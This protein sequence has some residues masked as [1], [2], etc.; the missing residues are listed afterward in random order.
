MKEIFFRKE[1]SQ[2]RILE[3][4]IAACCW[5]EISKGRGI[6]Y[7]SLFEDRIKGKENT[8]EH[9]LAYNELEDLVEIHRIWETRHHEFPGL[10]EKFKAIFT[11][12]PI[13]RENERPESSGNRPRNDSFV[14]FL[15]GSLIDA[16][17]EVLG[18]DGISKTGRNPLLK[19][20]N[21]N[22]F[23]SDIFLHHLNLQIKIECKRPQSLEA[24][25]VRIKEARKQINWDNG[26][27]GVDCSAALRP[28]EMILD[29]PSDKKAAEFLAALLSNKVER[30]VRGQFNPAILGAILHMR[31]PVHTIQKV[32]PILDIWGNSIT[33]RNPNSLSTFFFMANPDSPNAHVFRSIKDIY[34]ETFPKNGIKEDSI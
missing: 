1:E 2:A 3:R 27:I 17:I 34:M 11:K 30:V 20:P 5:A 16:G 21:D 24:I 7:Q 12:G 10:K 9:I 8:L 4:L 23:K 32:S 22:F 26:I 15:A 31:A 28:P 33:I 29:A 6:K 25:L 13:L 18:I 14:I 19:Q